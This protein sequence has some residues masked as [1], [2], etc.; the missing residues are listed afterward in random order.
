[1]RL[2]VSAAVIF[3]TVT[4][5]AAVTAGTSSAAS[6]KAPYVV[7]ATEDLSG[8]LSAYGHW[9]QV[10]WNAEF[11]AVNKA[12]GING[13]KVQLKI[14]DDQSELTTAV[15]NTKQFL[16]DNTVLTTASTLSNIC[17]ALAP[18][19]AQAKVP[20]SCGTATTTLLKPVEPYVF[21]RQ[22]PG[23][24][25]AAPAVDAIST[26][27][28]ASKPKVGMYIVAAADAIQMADQVTK[29]VNQK[30]WS[31]SDEEQASPSATSLDPAQ[32]AKLA[33]SK[34]N[35]VITYVATAFTQALIKG[36]RGD[37]YGGPVI[38]TVP[39]AA[40]LTALK[41][42]KFY[43]LFSNQYIEPNS[44]QSGAAQY[45][46][47]MK[48]D[49][50]TGA[51]ALNDGITVVDYLG[52]LVAATA[53]KNCGSTC[54]AQ[55]LAVQMGKTMLSEPG[56]TT[57]WGYSPKSHNAVQTFYLYRYTGGAVKLVQGNIPVGSF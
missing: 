50:V 19:A 37:G 55:Q 9:V 17:A 46:K 6:S 56:I 53:L 45:V 7:T 1:V 34:P 3:S 31:V 36:L 20:M 43:E 10:S 13:H 38:S 54:T 51:A 5:A 32:I 44:T 41:D 35:V 18:T 52:A 30:G 15:A 11:N 22:T 33:A 24:T 27:T 26:V 8:P 23:E 48:A 29:L 40:S 39:D 42:P 47:T 25:T 49:G 28:H 2:F 12:G 16:G 57:K 4:A 21:T 14:L